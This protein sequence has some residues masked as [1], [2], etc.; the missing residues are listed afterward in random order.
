MPLLSE[1]KRRINAI[2]GRPALTAHVVAGIESLGDDRV[3]GDHHLMLGVHLV[4]AFEDSIPDPSLEWL[5]DDGGAD[6]DEPLPRDL[7]HVDIIWEVP[8]HLRVALAEVEDLL[9]RQGFVVGHIEGLDV[10]HVEPSLLPVGNVLEEVH[11][12]ILYGKDM[13]SSEG[14]FHLPIGGK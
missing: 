12:H 8:L 7:G 5:P 3:G 2:N 9:D 4:V 1:I 13:I 10:V 14:D 11:R 6:I